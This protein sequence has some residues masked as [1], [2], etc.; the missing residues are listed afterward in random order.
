LL[1]QRDRD[2]APPIRGVI[3]A[4][5]VTGDQLVTATTGESLRQVMWPKIGGAQALN[6]AFPI[7]SL[8]FLFFM[9]S[10]GSVF[11][12]PGQ[13]S[14]A[15]ANSYLD[16]LARA[17]HGQGCHSVSLDWGAWQG[18]GFAADAQLVTEELNRLGSRAFTP[19][20]AFTAWDHV[21]RRDIA[22]AIVVPVPSEAE[23]RPSFGWQPTRADTWSQMAAV[24]VET[25]LTDTIRALVARELRTP[26]SEL[27]VDRPF[28]ELGLD[29]MMALSI[30]RDIEQLAGLELSAIML[31]NHPTIAKLAAYLTKK[32]L[33]QQE[34]PV[35]DIDD[36]AGPTGSVLDPL[37]ERVESTAT[38][39]TESRI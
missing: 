21:H 33:P 18:L 4:A 23:R 9:A 31:W 16:A 10:A 3:H 11:G 37:F 32:L 34:I 35:D 7:G 19:D 27:E 20:E 36:L 29:S 22:Q 15:A 5:G 39:G 26:E 1:A 25:E 6:A 8:D 12:I 14:Y 24:D 28:V 13:G 30:R 2:G 17:R 38:T